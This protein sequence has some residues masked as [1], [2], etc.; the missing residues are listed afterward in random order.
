MFSGGPI[1]LR[2][3]ERRT[4]SGCWSSRQWLTSSSNSNA[5]DTRG[6]GDQSSCLSKRR[7][8][9]YFDYCR[10]T[11]RLSLTGHLF[12]VMIVGPRNFTL[13][14]ST[15]A[16]QSSRCYKNSVPRQNPSTR[17]FTFI[18]AKATYHKSTRPQ[19]STTVS[20]TMAPKQATLGYVKTQQTLGCDYLDLLVLKHATPC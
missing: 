5:C 11:A 15:I 6:T 12:R 7:I 13:V 18:D 17:S 2:P 19:R 16:L 10:F 9:R 4:P 8:S 14:R 3:L 1:R 20:L